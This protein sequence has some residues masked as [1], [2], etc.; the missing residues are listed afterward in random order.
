MLC[1]AAIVMLHITQQLEAVHPNIHIVT[2]WLNLFLVM[3]FCISGFLYANKDIT[4]IPRWYGR[5]FFEIVFP[6]LLVGLC[7]ISVFALR[8]GISSSQVWGSLLSCV[9]LQV[10]VPD[11]W[12]FV[13]LWYLS[14]ILFFYLT[15]PLLQK[16]PCKQLPALVFWGML[17]GSAVVTQIFTFLFKKFTG[18]PLLSA[19]ILLRV[20]LPYFVFRRYDISSKQ[21]QKMAWIF[22]ILSIAAIGAVCLIRYNNVIAMPNAIAETAFVYTQTLAGFTLFYWL[23]KAFSILKTYSFVWKI[24]DALSYEVY[25]T[26]CLFIGYRTSWIRKYHYSL[27]GIL[28]SLLFTILTSIALHYF[29]MLVKWA[30]VRLY[31]L[32]KGNKSP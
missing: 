7:T 21:L 14:Y 9:G 28:L 23:Y 22:T 26:H 19:G 5:R 3:F 8:G 11:S 15:V 2:D 4:A 10:Y 25:L 24:S 1:T 12:M 27:A 29:V 32:R 17:A 20:Y 16:I 31:T 30:V 18:I 13:Q 6:S